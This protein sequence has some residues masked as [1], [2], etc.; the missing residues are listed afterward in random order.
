M[1]SVDF[2]LGFNDHFFSERHREQAAR[3]YR[4]FL[5]QHQDRLHAALADP[6]MLLQ[7]LQFY[8][9]LTKA[10]EREQVHI[11]NLQHPPLLRVTL[12]DITTKAG[13]SLVR[14]QR[15]YAT[16]KVH[17]HLARLMFP[18]RY[19]PDWNDINKIQQEPANSV[20]DSFGQEFIQYLATTPEEVQEVVERKDS[21][22]FQEVVGLDGSGFFWTMAPYVHLTMKERGLSPHESIA[23]IL[24]WVIGA[25]KNGSEGQ[26]D[27]GKRFPY[28]HSVIQQTSTLGFFPLGYDER[29]PS[30]LK[31]RLL[32]REVTG[33]LVK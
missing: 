9:D 33:E 18:M 30:H 32:A 22:K 11:L 8:A 26:H 25:H 16:G 27:L 14:E 1:N 15:Q 4:T 10:S 21:D 31:A 13:V 3:G 7:D 24:N 5:D 12:E 23:R 28:A 19:S 2:Y 20:C 6:T 29:M 17:W